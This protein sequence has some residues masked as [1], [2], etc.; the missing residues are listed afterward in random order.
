M[1]NFKK[2][3]DCS[4]L[5]KTE[6][7][8]VDGFQGQETDVII[9]SCVRAQST[10]GSIGCVIDVYISS[11]LLLNVLMVM[12]DSTLHMWVLV[13][14]LQN[15]Y[16]LIGNVLMLNKI[17]SQTWLIRTPLISNFRLICHYLLDTLH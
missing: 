17:H 2:Y 7:R 12:R 15:N 10:T 13:L 6:V 11:N 4:G 14:L 16:K 5:E 3:I 9:I 8:T 1:I